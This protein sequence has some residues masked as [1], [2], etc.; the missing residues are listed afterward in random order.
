MEATAQPVI[1]DMAALI[2]RVHAFAEDNALL[3]QTHETSGDLADAFGFAARGRGAPEV[4]LA[5]NTAVELGHPS[6]ASR[7]ILLATREPDLVR[8]GRVRVLGPDTDALPRGARADFAQVVM[9]RL[10]PGAV[11]DP[12]ALD[13]AQFLMH[14]L[15]GYMVRCVP[16]RLWARISNQ[17]LASGLTLKTV[18]AALIAAFTRDFRGVAAAEVLFVTADRDRVE[19]LAPIAAEAD[20]LFGKHKKL[21]IGVDGDAECAELNCDACD[22]KPVCDNLRDIVIKR[23]KR[24]S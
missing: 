18:G 6:A 5:E 12:F 19:A 9:L 10:A 2:R 15:P 17:A 13:N 7:A 16:G 20:I 8:P 23:R 21:V 24:M 3:A 4:I 14:R 11:P 1:A 22:E